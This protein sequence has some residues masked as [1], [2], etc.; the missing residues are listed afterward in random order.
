[1][2]APKQ[3]HPCAS[4]QVKKSLGCLNKAVALS[5]GVSHSWGSA[6]SVKQSTM[7]NKSTKISCTDFSES[8]GVDENR[9]G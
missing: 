9:P 3:N 5:C 8:F 1:M 2:D 4:A 6:F 7:N